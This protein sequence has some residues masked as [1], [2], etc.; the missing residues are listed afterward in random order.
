MQG[1]YDAY[2]AQA[3]KNRRIIQDRAQAILAENDFILL[4]VTAN[5]PRKIGTN[6]SPVEE[7]LSDLFTVLANLT[8]HPSISFPI[9]NDLNKKTISL[10]LISLK[11][12]ESTLFQWFALSH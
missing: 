1:Y 7:Y 6:S 8:G 2:F 4:P 3:Q 11:E 10:Q 5:F 12:R 9:N